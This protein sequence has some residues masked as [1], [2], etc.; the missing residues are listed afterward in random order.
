MI[1]ALQN[2]NVYYNNHSCARHKDIPI[3]VLEYVKN[4]SYDNL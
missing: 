1:T 4:D 3:S 2:K